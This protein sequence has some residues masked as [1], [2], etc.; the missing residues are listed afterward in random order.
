M[1]LMVFFKL[2]YLF[3]CIHLCHS[4]YYKKCEEFWHLTIFFSFATCI[5]L[6]MFVCWIAIVTFDSH[7]Y[8]AFYFC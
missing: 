8:D 5:D 4:Q 1:T 2:I 7:V 6:N 3:F